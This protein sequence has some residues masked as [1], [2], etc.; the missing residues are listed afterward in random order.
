MNRDKKEAYAINSRE[1][2]PLSAHKNMFQDASPTLGTH[3]ERK[4]SEYT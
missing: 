2:A 3:I 1:T 4:I